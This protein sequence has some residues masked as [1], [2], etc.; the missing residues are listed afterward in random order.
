MGPFPISNGYMYILLAVD[1]VS[2][3]VEAIPTKTNDARVVLNFLQKNIFTRFGTPRALIS[4]GGSHFCSKMFNNMMAKYGVKHR[5]VDAYHPQSN[6]QAEVSNRE[7]KQI[8]EKSMSPYR[9][10][11]GK[12]CHLPVELEHKAFWAVKKLNFNMTAVGEKRKLQISE[13]EE[14]REDAFENAQIYKDRTKRWHDKRILRREFLLGKLKSRWSG[15]FVI[16]NVLSPGGVI[17]LLANDGRAFIVNGQRIKH[18]NEQYM[19][20]EILTID[21]INT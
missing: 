16:K 19:Q 6:G 7:I 5:V 3:W 17:E 4:D 10:V 13:L 8:L 11:F 20:Q 9:L 21:L 12:S 15:P 14:F 18:Y 2:K 1:Y